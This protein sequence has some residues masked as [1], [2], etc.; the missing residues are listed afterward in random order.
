MEYFSG[1]FDAEGSV[2]LCKD[3]HFI[4]STEL[5]NEEVPNLF[6]EKFGGKIYS[7]QRD[8]RKKTWS[9]M[10]ATNTDSCLNFIE[11]VEPF[12]V[13]KAAQLCRLRDYL[14]QSREDRRATRHITSSL[15]AR[16]K[17]PS[18]ITRD[19]IIV[20]TD[21][22]PDERFLKWF[23]GFLDGDGNLCIYEYSGKSSP[24]FDSWI[25]VF[26]IMPEAI[27][28][29][30]SRING[31]ISSYKGAKFPIW[32][33][34]CCQKDSQ[35]VCDSL[36]PYLKIKKEQCALVSKFLKIKKTKIRENAYSFDQIN[37]IR[38]IIRQIKHL[39][40]L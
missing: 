20:D 34:V 13:I 3:G 31:S 23:S 2:S 16:L 8:K 11:S 38:D 9:W 27:S 19:Q 30:K 17:K 15:I 37:E 22:I 18:L 12:S 29:I 39:N 7:R 32:K 25:G 40:S 21:T 5:A 6:K 4:I 26:N 14:N 35:L 24:I 36:Y 10:I 28:F 33:W 1:L